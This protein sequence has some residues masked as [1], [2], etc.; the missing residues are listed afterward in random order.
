MNYKICLVCTGVFDVA[1][2]RFCKLGFFPSRLLLD[3]FGQAFQQL[4][5]RCAVC[6]TLRRIPYLL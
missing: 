6:L 3:V 1:A 4:G 2:C 5:L